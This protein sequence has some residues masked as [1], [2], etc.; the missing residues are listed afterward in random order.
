VEAV[1]VAPDGSWLA[2]AGSDD[3]TVRIWDVATGQDRATL[4]GHTGPVEA[5]EVAPDGNWLVSGGS[6][7]GTVRIWDV[8]TG[9]ARATLEGHSGSVE[10]VAVAPDGS[11]LATAG[12]DRTVRIWDV[13][14]GQARAL[15][16]LDNRVYAC[17][18]LGTNGLA[19]G[20]LAG[21]Y[22]FDFLAD[23]APATAGP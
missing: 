1:A 8:A 21:L 20:G 18:W 2:S 4:R 22:L 17:A 15:M 6:W 13:A 3:G 11:W 23:T 14:T 16:R 5:V 10:A 12:S 19:I 9:Q 7:D